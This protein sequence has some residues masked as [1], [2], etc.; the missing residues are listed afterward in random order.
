MKQAAARNLL[1]SAYLSSVH[2]PQSLKTIKYLCYAGIALGSCAL[3]LALIIT[4]GFERDI[5]IK[6]KGISSDAVIES[7]GNQLNAAELSAYIREQEGMVIRGIS[8][9]STRHIIFSHEETSRVLFLRAING[10]DEASTTALQDKIIAPHKGQLADL[11]APEG[12][13]LIGTQCATQNNLWLGSDLTMYVPEEGSKAKI[14]LEKKTMHLAGIFKLGLEDYDLNVAY[15]SYETFRSLYPQTVGADQLAVSFTTKN[16]EAAIKR[17]RAQ[18]PALSIR[19]WKELYPDLV[20]S[21]ELEKYAISIVLALIGLVASMLIVCLLFMFTHYKRQ[22]IAILQTIGMSNAAIQSLF[23]RIGMTIVGRAALC[24]ITIAC[25]VG[26]FIETYR[27]IRLPDIYY[28]AYLPAAVEPLHAF[29]VAALTILLGYGACRF[30]LS[31]LKDI[32]LARILR[33]A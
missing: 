6:M 26:W 16:P 28:I 5:G 1:A 13:I 29:I 20:A 11:L 14:A 17:L 12:S 31:R 32:T 25:L 3:M 18:L 9:S 7:P 30:P 23:V 8:A 4:S 27:P 15:C 10:I 33:G 22:D 21:L 24:G 19:S 2:A